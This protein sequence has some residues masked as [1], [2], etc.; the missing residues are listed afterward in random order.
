MF[1]MYVCTECLS[2]RENGCLV[3]G[4][5]ALIGQTHCDQC[6]SAFVER[7]QSTYYIVC[8]TWLLG[9][10]VNTFAIFRP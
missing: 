3:N 4:L 2:P 5:C 1:S 6:V 8:Y 9:C 10:L 7:N